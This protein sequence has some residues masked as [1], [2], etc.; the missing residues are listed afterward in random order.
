MVRHR[1]GCCWEFVSHECDRFFSDHP[2]GRP[3][4]RTNCVEDRPRFTHEFPRAWRWD[5]LVSCGCGVTDVK[6]LAWKLRP[7]W[8]KV[9][10]ALAWRLFRS[11]S[12]MRS[13]G[14]QSS[15]CV[16]FS[17]KTRTANVWASTLSSSW[18]LWKSTCLSW[19]EAC[20][21][22]IDTRRRGLRSSELGKVSAF[23][24]CPLTDF[25]ALTCFL[26]FSQKVSGL[27][28]RASARYT[29]HVPWQDAKRE[30]LSRRPLLKWR[31]P[32]VGVQGCY[33]G[34]STSPGTLKQ[35]Q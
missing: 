18:D 23:S 13:L 28:A 9:R 3:S 32:R 1:R 30:R 5:G 26:L 8:I 4:S 14:K 17:N 2:F 21:V 7:S 12:D 16:H 15:A 22:R 19:K 20:C 24:A 11:F 6:F 35:Q 34:R 25:V 29:E 10:P 31:C 27:Q 33:S